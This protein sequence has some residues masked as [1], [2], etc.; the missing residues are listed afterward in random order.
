MPRSG[1]C[2][3]WVL[4]VALLAAAASATA[5]EV[6]PAYLEITQPDPTTFEVVWKQ[7]V[8]GEVAVHLVPHLSNGWLER[9]PLQQ[10]T[11]G[12]FLIRSWRVAT[13]EGGAL[14]GASVDI[15]GLE[16]TITDVFARVRLADGTHIDTVIHP[17]APRLELAPSAQH[18]TLPAYVLLGIEHILTGP[19]HLLFVQIGRAH[20]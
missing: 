8:M 2:V 19:D 20:V 5:H 16:Y 14:A 4:I 9:P 1:F 15:E 18:F 10:Y 13:S 7:P 12:G 6:R 3:S 17:G 11:A